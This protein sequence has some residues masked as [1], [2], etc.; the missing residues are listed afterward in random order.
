MTMPL[1]VHQTT[2]TRQEQLDLWV[3]RQGTSYAALG[4]ILGVT[5]SG[6]IA[7][8]KGEHAP[9]ERV[10][11]MRAIRVRGQEIPEELLPVALDV[12][13]GPKSMVDISL[14]SL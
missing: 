5:R 6:A 4:R 13:P 12:K 1:L 14:A 9:T 11:Q 3:K 8:F 2:M 10:K 7:L